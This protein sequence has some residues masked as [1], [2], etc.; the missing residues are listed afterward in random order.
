MV[1][2]IDFQSRLQIVARVELYVQNFS[3]LQHI[4]DTP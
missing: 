4:V 3:L 1:E 2:E